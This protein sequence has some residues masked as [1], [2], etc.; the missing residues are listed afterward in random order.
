MYRESL[1]PAYA[2]V[3][4]FYKA[5]AGAIRAQLRVLWIPVAATGILGVGGVTLAIATSGFSGLLLVMAMPLAG[6]AFMGR[7]L[8]E[9]A[10]ALDDLVVDVS[11]STQARVFRFRSPDHEDVEVPAG[12]VRG[13]AAR[14]AELDPA[15][16]PRSTLPARSFTIV[17]ETQ[18]GNVEVTKPLVCTGQA[19][20]AAARA[21]LSR[22]LPE[23]E[24]K[25]RA[26]AAS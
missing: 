20:I 11:Y 2:S 3:V 18:D 24:A 6:A 16:T 15:E 12:D 26:A 25:L 22:A 17:C 1:P 21:H 19:F 8:R 14:E 7:M 5:P 23:I 13:L 4:K 9:K 10:R